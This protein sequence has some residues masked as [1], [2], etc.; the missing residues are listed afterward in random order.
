MRV[1]VKVLSPLAPA[2][3]VPAM[4]A[5]YDLAINNGRVMDPETIRPNR[6]CWHQGRQDYCQGLES[7]LRRLPRQTRENA[8]PALIP[9]PETSFVVIM[10]ERTIYK[11][12]IT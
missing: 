1:I 11:N 12:T 2:L 10:K 6:S 7:A 5:D 3:A 9:M 8:R 4:A